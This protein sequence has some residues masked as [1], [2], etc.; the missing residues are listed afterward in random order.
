MRKSI[1]SLSLLVIAVFIA[2]CSMTAKEILPKY[3]PGYIYYNDFSYSTLGE[4]PEDMRIGGLQQ[5]EVEVV[6]APDFPSERAV[7]LLAHKKTSDHTGESIEI[8]TSRFDLAGKNPTTVE[9]DYHL[10][11]VQEDST[12]NGLFFY[13]RD[14]GSNYRMII[15]LND[16]KLVWNASR[17]DFRAELGSMQSGWNHVRIVANRESENATLFLNDMDTPVAERLPFQR[18]VESWDN[19]E[20]LFR[21]GMSTVQERETHFGKISVKIVD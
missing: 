20:M 2:G 16:G 8:V 4:L 6:V 18:P 10:K 7:K 14:T 19:L 13:V 17:K 21:Q 9:I 3:P 1:R 12:Q 11:W 15:Q 5:G